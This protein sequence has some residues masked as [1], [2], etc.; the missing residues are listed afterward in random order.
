M[1]QGVRFGPQADYGL[2]EK[3]NLNCSSHIYKMKIIIRTSTNTHL[4]YDFLFIALIF[5][6]IITFRK[7]KGI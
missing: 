2:E 1:Y 3:Y 7:Y 5:W 4:M 6:A